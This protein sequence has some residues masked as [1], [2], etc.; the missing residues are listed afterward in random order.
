MYIEESYWDVVPLTPIESGEERGFRSMLLDR[1]APFE[2]AEIEWPD[3]GVRRAGWGS[4]GVAPSVQSCCGN[5][6]KFCDGLAASG[7]NSGRA[8]PPDQWEARLS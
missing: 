5:C 3:A 6:E 8:P 1:E 2:F 7:D 4:G